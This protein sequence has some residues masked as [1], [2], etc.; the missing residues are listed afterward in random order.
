MKETALMTA[1]STDDVEAMWTGT[2]RRL[3]LEG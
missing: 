2:R 3:G 1:V